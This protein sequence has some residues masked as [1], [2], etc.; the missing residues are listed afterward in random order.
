MCL[1][2]SSVA[3]CPSALLNYIA[4]YTSIHSR[5]NNV[6]SYYIEFV[7]YQLVYIIAL[8]L[9]NLYDREYILPV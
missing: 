2:M 1:D 7:R 6:L 5:V 9:V 4:I 8:R 3:T